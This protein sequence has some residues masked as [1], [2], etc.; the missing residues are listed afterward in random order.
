M[1]EN[2]LITFGGNIF[3]MIVNNTNTFQYRV[4]YKKCL[5]RNNTYCITIFK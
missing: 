4:D 2:F 5:F 3:K 1:E